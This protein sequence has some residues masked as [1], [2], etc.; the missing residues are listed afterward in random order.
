MDQWHDAYKEFLLFFMCCLTEE[1]VCTDLPSDLLDFMS[2]KISRRL[3]KLALLRQANSRAPCCRHAVP[4]DLPLKT[5]G[6]R[7]RLLS[8]YPH[9]QLDLTRD[10]RVSLLRS[11]DYLHRS[12]AIR[13]ISPPDL[14]FNPNHCP[15]GVLC[16]LLSLNWSFF[17]AIYHIELHVALYDVERAVEQGLDA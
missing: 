6:D 14:P 4:F 3:R 7:Y 17:E 10:L 16:E 8:I 5:G 13:R 9:S 11:R 2:A 12:L 15:R 1:K